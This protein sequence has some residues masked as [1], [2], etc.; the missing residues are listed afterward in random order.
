MIL[1]RAFIELTLV[2]RVIKLQINHY[3]GGTNLLECCNAQ[4]PRG[5]K[6]EVGF[7]GIQ[8]PPGLKV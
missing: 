8:G 6:G 3:N 7:P 4:G 2:F 1:S 5:P